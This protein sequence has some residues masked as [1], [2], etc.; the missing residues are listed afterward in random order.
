MAAN[1]VGDKSVGHGWAFRMG[2]VMASQTLRI[3][4]YATVDTGLEFDGRTVRYEVC[5]ACK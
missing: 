3:L 5:A 4:C 1:A 2:W